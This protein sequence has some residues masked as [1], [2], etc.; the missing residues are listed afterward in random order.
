AVAIQADGK[1][2]V[3]GGRNIVQCGLDCSFR[4]ALSRYTPRGSLDGSFGSGGKVLTPFGGDTVAQ[5]VAIQRDGSIVAAGG[6][7][8]Y[9]ALARYTAQGKLDPSFGSGGKVRTRL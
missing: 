1:L 7:A 8:G 3:A 6:G 9:F 4:F 5:A 2:V